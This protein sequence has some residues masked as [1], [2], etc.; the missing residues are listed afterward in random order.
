MIKF[1]R[2]KSGFYAIMYFDI[3]RHDWVLFWSGS[4]VLGEAMKALNDCKRFIK[5]VHYEK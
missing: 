4:K 5:G 1:T 3:V 2:C